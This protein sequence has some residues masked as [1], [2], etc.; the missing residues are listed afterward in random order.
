MTGVDSIE[1]TEPAA[2]ACEAGLAR[3]FDF[4]GKR[5]NGVILGTL[6]SGPAGFAELRRGVGTITDSVL[7]D[8]LTELTEGA[9]SYTHL[10][11]RGGS[12]L[13][14]RRRKPPV[15][16]GAVS[17][18]HLPTKLGP[19]PGAMPGRGATEGAGRAFLPYGVPGIPGHAGTDRSGGCPGRSEGLR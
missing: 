11:A 14:P 6:S 2:H 15:D 3:A 10:G 1:E 12:R 18:T 16:E 4:L 17:Y 7:S 19:A 5:W 9:V 8:R 13:A